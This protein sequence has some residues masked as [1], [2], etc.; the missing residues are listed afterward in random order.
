MT[1][2]K[3]EMT[4]E[5]RLAVDLFHWCGRITLTGRNCPEVIKIW[6]TRVPND[7][8]EI[9]GAKGAKKQ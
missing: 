9:S 1:T 7:R 6:H 2:D 8:L 4:A 5:E 3:P